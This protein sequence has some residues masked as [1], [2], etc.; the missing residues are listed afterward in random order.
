MKRNFPLFIATILILFFVSACSTSK[1][2]NKNIVTR[3]VD[4][5][6]ARDNGYFNARLSMKESERTLWEGQSDNYEEILPIFKYGTQEQASSVQPAM[7]EIVKKTSFVIQVH[8]KSKWV[9]DSYFLI[10][11]SSFYKRNYAEALSTFQYIV[12]E[13]S[14]LIDKKSANKRVKEDEDGKLNM[15]EKLKHQPV[16]S[17]AGI[18]VARS[19][20][21]LKKYSD[22]HTVI[23]VLK[24]RENFPTWLLSELYAVEADLYLKE[25]QNANAI[26]PLIAAI[27]NSDDKKI[28]V[29]YNFILAQLYAQQKD[30]DKAVATYQ[31]V[32]D[33]KPTYDMDFY[34]KLNMAKLTMDNYGISGKETKEGL[35]SLLKDEKYKEFYG[36]IYYT[37][38]DIELAAKNKDTGIMYLNKSVQSTNEGKQKGLSYMRLGDINYAD[39]AYK[40]AYAY[41]D[42]TVLNLP[43]DQ[44]RFDEVKLLRDNLKLLVD[45]LTII[46]TERK[47]QYWA[48]LSEKELEKELEKIIVEEKIIDTLNNDILNPNNVVNTNTNDIGDFYFYNTTLRSRGFSEFKKKWDT[49]KLEDNWRRSEKGI[50]GEEGEAALT[51]TANNKS[52]D[53]TKKNITM[54]AII[55]SIPNTPEKIAISNAKIAAA[56][57]RGGVIYKENFGNKQKAIVLFQDNV[58]NYPANQFEV[59]SLYQL[60]RLT[61]NP[62]Q[63][64]YKN[65]ILT[66]YPESDY[67]KVIADPDYFKKRDEKKNALD[68]YY[69]ETYDSLITKNY[70][71]VIKRSKIADSIFKPNPLK[72]KFEMLNALTFA[73]AD[74]VDLFKNEL[75]KVALKYPENEVGIR[76]QEI[77]DYLRRGSVIDAV[78]K[79]DKLEYTYKSDEEQ[80]FLFI[81]NTTGKDA[82][83]MKSN[84]ATFN[85]SNFATDNLKISSLLLGKENSIIMVK[86]F[87]NINTAMNYYFTI[88]DNV[89]L[90]NTLAKEAFTPLIISKSNYVQFYKS[91]DIEGYEVYFE[92]NYLKD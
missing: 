4:D 3:S 17:E 68:N 2:G 79:L 56:L 29:R 1:N 12:S 52:I 78:E 54:D 23:S 40:N 81:M 92:D 37:L 10:G 67:T 25:N 70:A 62:L 71:E 6:I 11:K 88:K 7:D 27:E 18:W 51:D 19:L 41:Y 32:L 26:K 85:A 64:E 43:R 13:Y 45:Q 55:A 28:N 58:T 50:F 8:K 33:S 16:A 46:E 42:S 15:I 48:G 35:L 5:L 39:L 89:A 74:S 82:T 86:S 80:Y 31:L 44:D 59:Q 49:R 65:N 24:S 73:N 90:Y 36:L 34:A 47:L 60:Y 91:K 61:G 72:P 53:L 75:Q 84:I 57:Y 69:T 66:K 87:N 9:D 77:L 30:Y 76:A 20:V 22:A 63:D 83:T 38:A 14:E 21:E